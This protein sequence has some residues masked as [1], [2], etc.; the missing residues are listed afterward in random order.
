MSANP[1][2]TGPVAVNESAVVVIRWL[3]CTGSGESGYMALNDDGTEPALCGGCERQRS[4][5]ADWRVWR[6]ETTMKRQTTRKLGQGAVA[7]LLFAVVLGCTAPETPAPTVAPTITPHPTSG[8]A[9]GV[10]VTGTVARLI[11]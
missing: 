5:D 3:T 11:R 8:P 10:V 2:Q 9:A 4:A 7:V 6:T 1:G